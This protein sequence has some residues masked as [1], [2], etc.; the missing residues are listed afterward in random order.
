MKKLGLNKIADV[1]LIVETLLNSSC[2]NE[3]SGYKSD[4]EKTPIKLSSSILDVKTQTAENS[5]KE[6]DAIGLFV[7]VQS[8]TL[9]QSR[10][11]DNMRFLYS[12]QSGFIPDQEIYY[13]EE[14]SVCDF[15]SYYPYKAT[16]I[17]AKSSK[18]DVA[19]ESNQI[20]DDNFSSSDFMVAQ[21]TGITPSDNPVDLQH[22]HL[23]CKLKIVLKTQNEPD[24]KALFTSNPEVSISN[25]YTNATYDFNTNALDLLKVEKSMIPHGKWVLSG[26]SL[27]GK[28]IIL[29]PQPIENKPLTFTLKLDEGIYTTSISENLSLRSGESHEVAINY[30]NLSKSISSSL[31]PTILPWKDSGKTDITVK[32]I[33]N[34]VS[35]ADL[36][37]QE[38]NVYKV[39]CNGIQIAEVCKEYLLSDNINA[40][41]IVAYP[42]LH[43]KSDLTNGTVINILGDTENEHGGKVSWNSTTNTMTYIRGSQDIV[44][45][46]YIT[47]SNKIS[48][49]EPVSSPNIAT[50]EKDELIDSRGT[51]SI[52]YP[53]V[54]IGT[55]YWIC[56]NLEATRYN[57]GKKISKRTDLSTESAGYSKSSTTSGYIFYN[58]GAISTGK[59]APIGWSI[60]NQQDWSNLKNYI[61]NN[62]SVLKDRTSWTTSENT[63]TNLTG[64]NA[65]ATGLFDLDEQDSSKLIY[66]FNGEYTGY[67]VIGDSETTVAKKAIFIKY[68]TN[69]IVEGENSA[70]CGYSVRC[71]RK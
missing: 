18:M 48:F 46:F 35:I 15:I 66:G 52:V 47:S 37:F 3:I 20:A 26:D 44:T 5:F 8:K 42:F 38:S 31:N 33:T 67:W 10:Y 17:H 14:G 27:V 39:M 65:I 59:L 13:P 45:N 28:E 30:D 58:K 62:T 34:I 70:T 4:E 23:F 41:A 61:Q 9:S 55:Q 21:A 2:V 64:F 69:D 12:L 24:I 57:N 32:G 7:I 36:T 16:G 29:I 71:I 43:G 60:P 11:V 19:V 1:L 40:Q 63:S 68:S 6:K 56:T 50:I 51:E 49:I 53:I 22:H 25:I 54:K